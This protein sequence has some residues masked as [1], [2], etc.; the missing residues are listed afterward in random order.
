MRQP[1]IDNVMICLTLLGQKQ[2]I[3]PVIL[4][5][6]G[7]LLYSKHFRE[8]SHA[9]ML[10]VFAAGGVFVFKHLLQSSRP[11]GIFKNTESYS[12]P[13]GHS[14]M[15]AVLFVGLAFLITSSMRRSRSR[16]LIYTVAFALAFMVGISRLYLGAHWFTDVFSAWLLS[17]A[18]L[19]FVIVSY[20]RAK[21]KRVNAL[22][23]F[24]F[25]LI[26]LIVSFTF[27]QYRHFGELKTEYTQ[28]DW[29]I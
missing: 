3:Y 4:V 7:Y 21:V 16:W 19:C 10:A 25:A 13:S 23:L 14:V 15:S 18:I 17:A 9:L 2:V 22:R 28:L 24:L 1:A 8:A 29:P 5:V 26:S 11:W 20:E 12:M 27:Y 6:F